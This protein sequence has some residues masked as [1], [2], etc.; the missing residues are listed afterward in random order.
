MLLQTMLRL[1]ET[2]SIYNHS[3]I[4]RSARELTRVVN[5]MTVLRGTME[6]TTRDRFD[7][8]RQYYIH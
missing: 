1:S 4:C 3:Y 8:G 7:Q 6:Y 2:K 5:F